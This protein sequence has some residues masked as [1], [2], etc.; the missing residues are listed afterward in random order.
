MSMGK[1]SAPAAPNYTNLAQQQAELSQAAARQATTANRVNQTTPFGSLNYSITGKDQYGNDIWSANQQLSPE[2]QKLLDYQNQTSLGLGQLQGG[3]L[4]YV[5]QML[6]KP[7]DTSQLPANQINPGQTAQD[8]LMAR[9]EP[10]FNK[11]QSA[12]ETQ[13]ANQGIGRGTEAWNNAMGE[14]NQSRNDAYTQAALQGMN[15]GQQARQQALQEQ[16]GLRQLPMQELNAL[17][18]GSQVQMP[19]YINAPQQATVQG[20]DLM[21]AAQNQYQAQLAATN[22]QNQGTS[23]FMGGLMGLGG[24]YV[25]SPSGSSAI[26]RVLGF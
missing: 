3:Q 20:P 21:G 23:N 24:A 2:Q 9:L 13:L 6:A 26:T 18:A 25:G 15:I 7:F 1:Q 4:D 8:A 19:N 12:L 14:M 10:S 5:R 22:A 16:M 11:R 17:R